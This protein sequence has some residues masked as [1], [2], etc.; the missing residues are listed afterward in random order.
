MFMYAVV[1][2][3]MC[4]VEGDQ[5]NDLPFS[6]LEMLGRTASALKGYTP[7]FLKPPQMLEGV[8]ALNQALL[9]TELKFS[10]LMHFPGLL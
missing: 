10:L 8:T 9:N 3:C 5:A 7:A 4:T 6:S 1:N 2:I